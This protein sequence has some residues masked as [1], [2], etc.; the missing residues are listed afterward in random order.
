MLL[1]AI[2]F[3]EVLS[4]VKF[5]ASVPVST[6]YILNF[7]GYQVPFLIAC[8]FAMKRSHRS[9]FTSGAT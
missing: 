1:P 6:G 7:V 8:A 2:G 5:G 9:C 4:A 3:S